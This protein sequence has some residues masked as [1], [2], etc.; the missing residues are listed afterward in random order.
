[1]LIKLQKKQ[2]ILEEK[3]SIDELRTSID[4]NVQIDLD[5]I[6]RAESLWRELT[7]ITDENGKIKDGYETRAK[8]ITGELSKALDTEVTIT[9]NVIDKYKE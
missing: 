9:N 7:K 6:D 2:E 4:S 3:K 8:V 5:H 1:M